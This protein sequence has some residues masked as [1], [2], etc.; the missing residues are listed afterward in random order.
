MQG[1]GFTPG[2]QEPSLFDLENVRRAAG[3]RAFGIALASGLHYARAPWLSDGVVR[4]VF[5]TEEAGSRSG[6]RRDDYQVVLRL[7]KTHGALLGDCSRCPQV[8]GPCPHVTMLAVD[9]AASA[10]L[11]EALLEGRSTAEAAANAP[12]LRVV[13]KAEREFDHALAAWLAPVVAAAPVEIAASPF[14]E[15]EGHV[16][17][18]YGDPSDG[19]HAP[20]LAVMVRRVGERKLFAARE[21]VPPVRFSAR[22]RRVLEHTRDRGTQRKATYA[23]GVEASLAIEAMRV[24]GGVYAH[25]YKTLLDFRPGVVRPTLT[26]GIPDATTAPVADAS[27]ETLSASWTTDATRIAFADAV[28]FPGPFSYVWTRGSYWQDNVQIRFYVL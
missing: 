27:L 28:F 11:R 23:L 13:L 18:A 12:G 24:H 20:S 1:S 22:D 26:L 5:A 9:I 10:P 15:V 16:G 4:A 6:N 17:R 7:E 25:G 19:M 21:I 14:A 3:P 8:F 2:G